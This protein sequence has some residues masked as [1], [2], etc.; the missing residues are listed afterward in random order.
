[1][2]RRKAPIPR[3]GNYQ[4]AELEEDAMDIPGI[5]Y[6]EGDS[7]L[8]RRHPLAKLTVLLLLFA[9]L[10]IFREWFVPLGVAALI[11]AA[12]LHPRLG[13]GRFFLLARRFVLF[14]ALIICANLI[15]ARQQGPLSA[16]AA[17]GLLQG[18][19][20]FDLLA[21][22]GLFLA[23]TDPVDLADSLLALLRPLGKA[24]FP[25]GGLSLLLMVVFGFLPL[26]GDEAGRL[27][28]A[29]A[30]RCGFGGGLVE[31]ARKAVPLLAA[32]V[33]GIMRRSEELQLSLAARGYNVELP[34]R[35]YM[36]R[37]L[38]RIDYIVCG[39]CVALFVIGVYAQS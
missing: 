11:L 4:R 19:R 28:M 26:V 3:R 6:V 15:L 7:F 2:H 29:L 33:V 18:L 39:V 14:L 30:T 16:R 23:V 25:L 27:G 38:N 1:M 34:K 36:K 20:V 10:F 9:A 8:H 22:T 17:A 35:L 24:G 32:L 12:H 13:I 37:P 5:H 21:A 31:R